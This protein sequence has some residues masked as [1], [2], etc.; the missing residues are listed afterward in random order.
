MSQASYIPADAGPSS[1]P[2]PRK[3]RKQPPQ[4]TIDDFWSSFN[5]DYPGK[6][7]SILPKDV[8]AKSKAAKQLKGTVVGQAALKSYDQAAAECEAAVQQISQEC[9][10]VNMRYRDKHFDI[11]FDLKKG[12]RRCL[13][14]IWG[15]DPNAPPEEAPPMPRAVKRVPQ[16][17]KKP[18]FYIDD[19]TAADV[20]QGKTGDCYLLAAVGA[21][22]NKSGLI[23]KVCVA[24][25][26]K[27]GVYGFVFHRGTLSDS[28][29]VR[30]PLRLSRWRVDTY[31]R[32]RQTLSVD[33]GL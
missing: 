21:L 18:Q 13:D 33:C 20:R 3:V 16:I 22:G 27:V 26:E 6:V 12:Y 2:A 25:D 17:F 7:L 29:S 28:L 32:R 14:G 10:R 11:E 5:T 1:P 23:N 4:K 8:Y 19:A 31:C 9:K 15:F 24:R 30:I